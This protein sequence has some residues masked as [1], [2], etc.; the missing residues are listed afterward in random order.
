MEDIGEDTR[1]LVRATVQ[2]VPRHPIW[3]CHFPDIHS[4]KHLAHLLLCDGDHALIAEDVAILCH[5]GV[6]CINSDASLQLGIEHIQFSSAKAESTFT[7]FHLVVG[8]VMVHSTTYSKSP[9]Q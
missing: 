9:C 2:E 1:L 5:Q 7:I 3:T 6:A 4:L 8:T